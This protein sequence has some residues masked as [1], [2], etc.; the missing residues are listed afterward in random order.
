MAS[1]TRNQGSVR[2]PFVNINQLTR[3]GAS[4]G[5]VPVFNSPRW[6]V[7]E[8]GG[9]AGPDAVVATQAGFTPTYL[10][11]GLEADLGPLSDYTGDLDLTEAASPIQGPG[12]SRVAWAVPAGAVAA[13]LHLECEAGS[14]L[15][16][17]SVVGPDGNFVAGTATQNAINPL[18]LFSG[19]GILNFGSVDHEAVSVDILL[20]FDTPAVDLQIVLASIAAPDMGVSVNWISN[21]LTAFDSLMSM[22]S[23]AGSD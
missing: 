14:A 20:K 23:R 3:S 8:G 7:G 11:D 4:N 22:I 21:N 9:G 10:D 17:V 5:D 16:G 2:A 18:I 12:A 1:S 15:L 6:G 19:P 13:L